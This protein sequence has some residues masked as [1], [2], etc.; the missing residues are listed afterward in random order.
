MNLKG[1]ITFQSVEMTLSYKEQIKRE[2]YAFSLRTPKI[3]GLSPSIEYITL[4]APLRSPTA[5]LEDARRDA[6]KFKEQAEHIRAIDEK[7]T[8]IERVSRFLGGTKTKSQDR[9]R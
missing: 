5:L 2:E 6:P 9:G 7:R 1:T 8:A 4:C 3:E